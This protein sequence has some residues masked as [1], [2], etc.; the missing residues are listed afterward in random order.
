MRNTEKSWIC[1]HING[2]VRNRTNNNRDNSEKLIET[3][4]KICEQRNKYFAQDK[5]VKYQN[6]AQM[7]QNLGYVDV[8]KL[9]EYIKVLNHFSLMILAQ[10]RR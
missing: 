8:G 4:D 3:V 1:F 7:D 10:S 9:R 5:S 6:K 2:F